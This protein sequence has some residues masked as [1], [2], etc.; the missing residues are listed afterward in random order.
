MSCPY[1]RWVASARSH[2][3]YAS[4]TARTAYP[5]RIAYPSGSNNFSILGQIF[6]NWLYL[7]LVPS[8]YLAAFYSGI[9]G[10]SGLLALGIW[11]GKP[12]KIIRFGLPSSTLVVFV[13]I[14]VAYS[15]CNGLAKDAANVKEPKLNGA[16]AAF[17]KCMSDPTLLIF[18]W[19]PTF[20]ASHTPNHPHETHPLAGVTP[21]FHP[22]CSSS[23]LVDGGAL[24]QEQRQ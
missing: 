1:C 12:P 24:P 2:S 22:S 8:Y 15:Y 9:V 7:G 20:R 6:D 11:K 16:S 18:A 17:E 13:V 5:N 3:T 19:A 21:R 4:P 23:R 10:G 14:S